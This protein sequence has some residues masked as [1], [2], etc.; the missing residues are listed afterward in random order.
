[1][2]GEEVFGP[3]LPVVKTQN[4]EQAI[5]LANRSPW[6]VNVSIWSRDREAV[7]RLAPRVQCQQ[8]WINRLAIGLGRAC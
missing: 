7:R 8:L 4:L 1:L 2:L 3:I 5:D 6:H